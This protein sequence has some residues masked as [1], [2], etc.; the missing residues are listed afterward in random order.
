MRNH[1]RLFVAAVAWAVLLPSAVS[2][3]DPEPT[4]PAVFE[5]F[6]TDFDAVEAADANAS[7]DGLGLFSDDVNRLLTATAQP[8][9]ATIYGFGDDPNGAPV[10]E[11]VGGTPAASGAMAIQLPDDWTPPAEGLGSDLAFAQSAGRQLA[12][13]DVAMFM[14][15]EFADDY[16][17][18]PAQQINEGFPLTL[19]DLPVWNSSFAGDTWEGANL[20]PNAVYDGASLTFDVKSYAPPQSFPIVDLPGFYYRSGNVMAMALGVDALETYAADQGVVFESALGPLADQPNSLSSARA[21]AVIP[22]QS[23][24]PVGEFVFT[25]TLLTLIAIKWYVHFTRNGLFTPGWIGVIAA[26]SLLTTLI[27][28]ARSFFTG[29]IPPVEAAAP[30]DDTTSESDDEP[31]ED[32]TEETTSGS[33]TTAEE[34]DDPADDPPA[35]P[36]TTSTPSDD[37]DSSFPWL[38][39]LLVGLGITAI[40][41][42]VTRT[43]GKN[44]D[45]ADADPDRV[46]YILPPDDGLPGLTPPGDDIIQS[47]ICGWE[48]EFND[49]GNWYTV[50]PLNPGESECCKYKVEIETQTLIDIT[51]KSFRQDAP[52]DRLYIPAHQQSGVGLDWQGFTGTR[53]GPFGRQDWQHG[54]GDPIDTEGEGDP[55]AYFQGH[56]GE[57][58]PDVVAQNFHVELSRVTAWLEPGCFGHENTFDTSSWAELKILATQECTN[59]DPG[60]ACPVEL[61]A[62]G[63][64]VGIAFG[65]QN[66]AVGH[67]HG[68]DIDELERHARAFIDMSEAERQNFTVPPMSVIGAWDGHDHETRDKSTLPAEVGDAEHPL[69]EGDRWEAYFLTISVQYAGQLV[70]VS[71][72]PVTERVSTAIDFDVNWGITLQGELEVPECVEDNCSGHPDRKCHGSANFELVLNGTGNTLSAGGNM[73]TLQRETVDLSGLAIPRITGLWEIGSVVGPGTGLAP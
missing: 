21:S 15:V 53:S 40:G 59:D 29:P 58:R 41:W 6:G 1:R 30:E 36:E 17:F 8:V 16:D 28:I 63:A 4:P 38:I 24:D 70:P 32:V 43:R 37:G 5:E 71:V 11:A 49:G 25:T 10:F 35:D 48:L 3:Q 64:A 12:P 46:A 22:A 57:E 31:G 14:W 51:D 56:Q 19:P 73:V 13:G 60:P 23:N 9:D 45:D 26:Y 34:T 44:D 20:I 7:W 2:A 55:E 62:F 68:T 33:D 69:K 61:N 27:M 65:D 50:K 47:R 18:D 39:V 42:G 67:A 54:D 66:L 72:W 52:A